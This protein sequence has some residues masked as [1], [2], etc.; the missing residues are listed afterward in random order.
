M[1]SLPLITIFSATTTVRQN[2]T[3][4]SMAQWN[5]NDNGATARAI[6]ATTVFNVMSDVVDAT[7]GPLLS[8]HC[9]KS[10]PTCIVVLAGSPRPIGRSTTS[11]TVAYSVNV[12]ESS[13]ADATDAINDFNAAM[14]QKVTRGDFAKILKSVASSWPSRRLLSALPV[15][16]EAAAFSLTDFGGFGGATVSTPPSAGDPVIVSQTVAQTLAPVNTPTD[17]PAAAA[18]TTG[19]K[20][21]AAPSTT[22]AVVSPSPTFTTSIAGVTNL[23]GPA[24][25]SVTVDRL[26]SDLLTTGAPLYLFFVFLGLYFVMSLALVSTRRGSSKIVTFTQGEISFALIVLGTSG[27]LELIIGAVML[28]SQSF[29]GPG[30]AIIVFRVLHLVPSAYIVGSLLGSSSTLDYYPSLLDREHFSSKLHVYG[31]LSLL[32]C[33]E[34]QLMR[35]FPWLNNAYT[36]RFKGYPDK[37]LVV[38][39]SLFKLVQSFVSF[40]CIVFFLAGVHAKYGSNVVG[41]AYAFFYI[42]MFLTLA[43]FLLNAYHLNDLRHL[44]DSENLEDDNLNGVE[45]GTTKGPAVSV[46]PKAKVEGAAATANPMFMSEEEK[47]AAALAQQQKLADHARAPR[48]V[49]VMDAMGGA[50]VKAAAHTGHDSEPEVATTRRSIAPPTSPPPA[51]AAP[52]S[53]APEPEPEPVQ[54][55]EPEPVVEEAVAPA[56]PPA[57]ATAPAAAP[58]VKSPG[59][60]RSAASPPSGAPRPPPPGAAGRLPPGAAPRPPPP[61]A[62]KAPP[63]RGAL[64]PGAVSRAVAPADN[65]ESN[66]QNL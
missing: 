57:A 65:A 38:L 9:L 25:A 13:R 12:V 7:G 15:P 34:C 11:I 58:A 64:P 18:P 42:S 14:G 40:V 21:P 46:T 17:A 4:V 52:V 37:H 27:L 5:G 30:A 41:A 16:L 23:L 39:C 59:P 48:R 61:G 50:Q 54:E 43:T 44:D 2:V 45:M 56:D 6:W 26:N 19:T 31:L 66:N 55:P 22:K 28:Q 53:A 20:K 1:P 62:L 51:V 36:R 49:S 10:T 60:P 47:A 32:S 63:P 8:P 3:G 29:K 33:N 35:F 24:V